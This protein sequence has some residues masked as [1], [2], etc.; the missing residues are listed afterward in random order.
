MSEFVANRATIFK[1]LEAAQW[2]ISPEAMK[3]LG[4]EDF[5]DAGYGSKNAYLASWYKVIT[6]LHAML[7]T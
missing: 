6:K 7:E 3:L 2:H 1:A 5:R 4:F